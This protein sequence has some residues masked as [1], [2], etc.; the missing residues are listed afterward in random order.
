VGKRLGRKRKKIIKYTRSKLPNQY[1]CPNCGNSTV[2]VVI[3]EEKE[4][5]RIMCS[6]CTLKS[7]IKVRQ[8]SSPIDAY[9]QFIDGYYGVEEN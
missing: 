1:L 8:E 2:Q 6:N 9:C 5:A 4:S 3:R 7:E